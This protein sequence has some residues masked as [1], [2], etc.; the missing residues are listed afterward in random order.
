MLLTDSG[1]NSDSF[2]TFR[3]RLSREASCCICSG[4]PRPAG[5][6]LRESQPVCMLL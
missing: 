4:I 2:V 1:S 6:R 3:F 5:A